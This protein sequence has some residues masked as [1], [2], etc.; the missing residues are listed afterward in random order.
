MGMKSKNAILL[1]LILLL[2]ASA[3][4]YKLGSESFWLD[5]GAT[6]LTLKKNDTMQI[7][8]SILR[9]GKILPDYY[10]YTHS[11]PLYYTILSIWADLFGMT[12]FSL[13]AFSAL[14]GSLSLIAV[15]YLSRYLFDDKIALLS[16]F[17]ASINLTLVWY[18][19]EARQYSYL[20]FLSLLSVI[21]LLKA[22]RHGKAMHIIG[23]LAVNA[24][25]I[26]S[27]I[28]WIL[29]IFF[30]SVYALYVMY[31]DYSDKKYIHKKVIAAFFVIFILCLP[32]IG[33]AIFSDTDIVRLYG[34]PE[35]QD[36]AKFGVYLSGWLYPKETLR[37]KLYTSSF[38]FN[39]YE[40]ALVSSFLLSTLLY[41][42]LFLI[43]ILKSFK[44]KSY[45]FLISMFFLP[46]L[47][48]LAISYIHP[49]ITVFMVKQVIYVIPVYLIFVSIG[50][51]SSRFGNFLLAIIA[52]SGLLSLHSYYLNT[53]KQQFRE[54][55]EF[56]KNNDEPVFLNI[57]SAQ[58]AFRY[59]YGEK[60]NVIGV[61]DLE[62]LKS[63]LNGID[64][65]WMLLTFTKYSDPENRIRDFLDANYAPTE[66]KGFF[67]IE[68]LHYE[69]RAP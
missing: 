12:E 39:L 19:Q 34:K 4:F 24:L 26:Y 66:K 35:V 16:T 23:F 57:V 63:N 65:F 37:E 49:S 56:L 38:D 51:L 1:I 45:I 46:V 41:G 13:R 69:R 10:S 17:L 32:I 48:S 53:D 28:T 68:L 58:V 8:G 31:R 59:Y 11:L 5:E 64:S 18:S 29:F 14:L 9:D 52:I 54:A 30:E 3:R 42:I 15:F 55:A 44:H 47:L 27:Q 33:R 25:I 61:K 22:L 43:G 7:F 62:E 67:D 2:G 50:V 6:A 36:I 40:F 20:L 21:F 60:D